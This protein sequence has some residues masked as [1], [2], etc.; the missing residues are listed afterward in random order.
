MVRSSIVCSNRS[1]SAANCSGPFRQGAREWN[2][3]EGNERVT[4]DN[5]DGGV[6]PDSQ[7]PR[8]SATKI[9]TNAPFAHAPLEFSRPTKRMKPCWRMPAPPCRIV[10]RWTNASSR[11][12]AGV[13]PPMQIAKGSQEKAKF[14]GYAQNTPMSLP[15]S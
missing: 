13:I 8:G 11:K 6:Q 9:R 14:Y 4:K 1:L 15:N 7:A 2:I 3:V 12:C 5:W 10:I